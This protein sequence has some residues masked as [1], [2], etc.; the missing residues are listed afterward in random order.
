MLWV[1]GN[2]F[3]PDARIKWRKPSVAFLQE[4][5]LKNKVDVIITTGPPHSLHLIGMDIKKSM[6]LPWI[7]DFRDPWTSIHY[8]KALR[9]SKVSEAKHNKMEAQVLN[10]A[11]S[12]VVTSPSTKREFEDG[13]YN[14]PESVGK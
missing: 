8:H 10:E 12:I 6:K 14:K 4:Y 5:L 3:I 13:S 1:R 7:A 9:L 11:D 2:F